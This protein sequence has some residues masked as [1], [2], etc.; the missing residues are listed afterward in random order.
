[1]YLC[2]LC[3]SLILSH[4]ALKYSFPHDDVDIL[5]VLQSVLDTERSNNSLRKIQLNHVL[6]KPC[7][8]KYPGSV[9]YITK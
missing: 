3:M 7:G 9:S 2:D 4:N 8:S 6:N 5:K 1:M